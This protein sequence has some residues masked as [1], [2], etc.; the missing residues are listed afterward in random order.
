MLTC[1]TFSTLTAPPATNGVATSFIVRVRQAAIAGGYWF[2]GNMTGEELD[3]DALD[4]A[5]TRARKK[6]LKKLRVLGFEAGQLLTEGLKGERFMQSDICAM[7][8]RYLDK[9]NLST[10]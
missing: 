9:V 1:T 4:K 2:D 3:K 8:E 6:W 5:T 10:R 7:M